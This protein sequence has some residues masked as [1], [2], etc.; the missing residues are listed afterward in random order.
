MIRYNFSNFSNLISVYN[1][2]F[3]PM[4]CMFN[5]KAESSTERLVLIAP[6]LC[7]RS[8]VCCVRENPPCYGQRYYEI[9]VTSHHKLYSTGEQQ[10]SSLELETNRRED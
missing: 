5:L 10:K 4:F 8:G 9:M 6:T 2:L 3:F 7:W 1:F